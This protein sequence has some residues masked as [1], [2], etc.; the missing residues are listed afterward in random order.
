MNTVSAECPYKSYH[1]PYTV[2]TD[3]LRLKLDPISLLLSNG[4]SKCQH[5]STAGLF[6]PRWPCY[7]S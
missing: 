5:C 7:C 2:V 6:L 3:S 1:K 4:P